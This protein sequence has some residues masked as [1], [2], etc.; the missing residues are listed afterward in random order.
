MRREL[1]LIEKKLRERGF[2]RVAGVDEAGRG[3]WAGPLVAAA[4]ILPEEFELLSLDDSKRLSPG[5]RERVLRRILMD[6]VS[7]SVAVMP[8]STVDE[9]GLQR[10]NLAALRQALL[11]LDVTPDYF[12]SDGFSLSA[13]PFPGRGLVRGDR[14][15][16]AVAAASVL[17]KVARDRIMRGIARTYPQYGFE[18]HVGYGTAEHRARLEEH[19]PSPVHRL[20]FRPLADS[21]GVQEALFGELE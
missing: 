3:A 16:G 18:R 12:V 15:V 1:R 19:G 9:I 6:A 21:A 10:C 8:A 20:T 13:L 4:V 14:Q 17:A 11:G 7:W 2:R 5:V